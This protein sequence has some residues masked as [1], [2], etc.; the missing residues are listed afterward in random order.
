MKNKDGFL[1][2]N[3][4]DTCPYENESFEAKIWWAERSYA[5]EY[6]GELSKR[7]Y[8]E[9]FVGKWDPWFWRDVMDKYD[10]MTK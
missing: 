10:T 4:E 9:A 7:A 3:G 8:I 5:S 6:D 1:F 2:Y